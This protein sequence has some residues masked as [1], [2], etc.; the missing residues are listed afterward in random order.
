VMRDQ[1][2]LV[3]GVDDF[4]DRHPSVCLFL[5]ASMFASQARFPP[6][7]WGNPTMKC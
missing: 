6:A 5:V 7:R 2:N 4:L 1:D 3:P